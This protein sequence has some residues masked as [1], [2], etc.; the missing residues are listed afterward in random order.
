MNRYG[1]RAGAGLLAAA[2][3]ACWASAPAV[4]SGAGAPADASARGFIALCDLAG[5]NVT[6]G[7]VRS[8]PFAWK[9][10]SSVAAPAAYRGRGE[11][12]ALLVY[13]VRRDTPAAYW[14]GDT[15]S[16]DSFY[17]N[18]RHPAAEMTYQ[19]LSLADIVR[20]FPPLD[21]GLYELRMHV[22]KLDYGTYSATYPATFIKITGSAWHV[23]DGGTQSCGSSTKSTSSELYA[24]Q[25]LVASTLDKRETP[26]T[27][28]AA[29]RRAAGTSAGSSGEADTAALREADHRPGG[30]ASRRSEYLAGVLAVMAA[31]G[32]GL[33]V[34]RRSNGRIA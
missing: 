7:S 8:A 17:G 30:S 18:R 3:A 15:L 19:D 20:E 34:R 16:A 6:G 31:V 21:D 10:V 12:A 2:I 4:A 1:R 5:H 28:P 22:G 13:Q 24:G 33:L 27:A 25:A 29:L 11:N 32:G 23:V 9:A 14:S 26:P